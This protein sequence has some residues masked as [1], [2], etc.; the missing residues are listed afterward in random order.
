MTAGI[1]SLIVNGGGNNGRE[2][3]TLQTVQI[4]VT[5]IR[6]DAEVRDFADGRADRFNNI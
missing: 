5:D 1:M 6:R 3:H 2:Q 4:P